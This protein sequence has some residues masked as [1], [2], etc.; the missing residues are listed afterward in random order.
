MTSASLRPY[1]PGYLVVIDAD[2]VELAETRVD[3]T[4]LLHDEVQLLRTH[5]EAGLGDGCYLV[6]LEGRMP[7]SANDD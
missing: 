7:S 3:I 2:G 6:H 1:P 4:G 5:F